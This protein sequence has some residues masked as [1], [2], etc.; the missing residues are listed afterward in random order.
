MDSN[1][2]PGIKDLILGL[3]AQIMAAIREQDR[4]ALAPLVAEDFVFRDAAGPA[5]S[6][7]EFLDV[8]MSVP[9]RIISV[10]GEELR[11]DAYGDVAVLTGVQR[12]TVEMAEGEE[13]SGAQVFTDL[14]A[15]RE[16]RWLLVFAHT[17]DQSG[18]AGA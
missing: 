11:V 6:K 16:G 18:E 1:T 14:F 9:I 13:V 17:V 3:E 2:A 7:A 10:E 4:E 8:A 15:R 12:S 5:L